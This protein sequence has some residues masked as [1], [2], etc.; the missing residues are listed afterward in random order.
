MEK[1]KYYVKLGWVD[2]N[3]DF[4]PLINPY[5]D[6]QTSKYYYYKLSIK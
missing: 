2:N 4:F 5:Y 1:H 3:I 6:I